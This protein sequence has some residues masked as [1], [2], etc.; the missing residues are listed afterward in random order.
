MP[1]S[2]FQLSE[3]YRIFFLCSGLCS[4]SQNAPYFFSILAFNARNVIFFSCSVPQLSEHHVNSLSGAATQLS[5]KHVILQYCH[6][7]LIQWV[8]I[9]LHS[10][11][12]ANCPIFVCNM[13]LASVST[14]Q[15]GMTRLRLSP[16]P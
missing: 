2:V 11:L 10:Y 15:V 3:G 8:I 16:L 14:S 6:F 5:E 9:G 1:C 7:Q 13:F 4:T 12:S